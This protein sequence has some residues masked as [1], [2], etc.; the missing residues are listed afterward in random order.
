MIQ[1]IMNEINEVMNLVDEKQID[2]T[3]P[4]FKKKQR[5]FI[6]GAG[7]SGFQAKGFAMRLM[8]IG[9]QD[10]VMGETI[11]PSIQKAIRGLLFQDQGLLKEL[12][13]IHRLPKN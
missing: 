11:T 6:T 10:Y 5:I 3:L 7:R 13:R 4:F 2:A 8:H 12:L 9:Y 1:T